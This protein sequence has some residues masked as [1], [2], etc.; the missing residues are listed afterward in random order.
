MTTHLMVDTSDYEMRAGCDTYDGGDFL[1]PTLEDVTCEPCLAPYRALTVLSRDFAL[2]LLYQAETVMVRADAALAQWRDE[3]A[4]P[5]P[6]YDPLLA[7]VRLTEREMFPPLVI[8]MVSM[9]KPLFAVS[10]YGVAAF[11]PEGTFW[12]PPVAGRH[13]R[14]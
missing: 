9:G 7:Q 10:D 1:T 14:D 12:E 3:M 6:A 8:D 13:R 4:T 5:P 11:T 2:S